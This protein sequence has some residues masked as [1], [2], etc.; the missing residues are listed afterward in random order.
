MSLEWGDHVGFICLVLREEL[1][2]SGEM[3]EGS[4]LC[5]VKLTSAMC[6]LMDLGLMVRGFAST[7]WH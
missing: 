4:L 2:L 3:T 1:C 5:S 7:A 6:F